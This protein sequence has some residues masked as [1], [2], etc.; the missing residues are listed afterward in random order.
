VKEKGNQRIKP[1]QMV[2]GKVKLLCEFFWLFTRTLNF[3]VGRRMIDK[4]Q[5]WKAGRSF[6]QG[7]GGTATVCRL[8]VE[9]GKSDASCV[10]FKVS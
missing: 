5:W 1:K 10:E 7:G 4:N 3:Y 9:A 2:G 8:E 6:L